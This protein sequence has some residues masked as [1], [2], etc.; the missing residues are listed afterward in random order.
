MK[1][2]GFGLM[3]LPL[4]DES[5]RSTVDVETVKGMVD[6]YLERG[7]TY[8]DTAHRYHNEASEPATRKALTE[9]YAREQYV[10]TNRLP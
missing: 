1:K 7:F 9:R 6:R 10:L 4:L 8:F 2:L 5:D 3:R